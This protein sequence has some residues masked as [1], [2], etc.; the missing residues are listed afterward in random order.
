M[1][2]LELKKQLQTFLKTKATRVYYERANH[3]STY[4]Y[5]VFNLRNSI[6]QEGNREDFILEIDVWGYED[7][8]TALETLVGNI[9]GDGSLTSPTGLHRKL[10]YVSDSISIK[11]YRESRLDIADSDERVRRRQLRYIAQVYLS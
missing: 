11:L 2:V 6:E 3:V 10:I 5:V 8:V 4:P 9:D 7:G 1:N